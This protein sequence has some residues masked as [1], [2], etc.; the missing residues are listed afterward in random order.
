MR[1][2]NIFIRDRSVKT[3]NLAKVEER[4]CS[5]EDNQKTAQKKDMTE[6]P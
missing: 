6:K 2:I 1:W 5:E 3:Q 4:K